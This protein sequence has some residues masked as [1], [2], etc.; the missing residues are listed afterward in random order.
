[1]DRI[2]RI[3]VFGRISGA[4]LF[5]DF[6]EQ[7]KF[8]S[9]IR[10]YSNWGKYSCATFTLFCFKSNTADFGR[11]SLP[12]QMSAHLTLSGIVTVF[13]RVIYFVAERQR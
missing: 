3:F 8:N 4:R 2:V 7:N 10:S 13:M 9:T 12:P 5:L 1:V 6:F 11:V